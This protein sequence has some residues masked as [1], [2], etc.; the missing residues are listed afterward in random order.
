VLSGEGRVVGDHLC[1]HP[2]VDHI[3]FTGSV[4]TGKAVLQRAALNIKPT[5]MELGGKSAAILGAD[6]NLDRALTS[7][8]LGIFE[9]AGQICSACSRL[10]VPRERSAEVRRW[11]ARH[12]AS[13]TVGP[14]ETDPSMGPLISRDQQIRVDGLIERALA[15]GAELVARGRLSEPSAGFFV[16][17][18]V[19]GGVDPDGE[20]AQREVFGP[21]LSI[22]EYHSMEQ[23]VAIANGTRFGLVAGVF[24]NDLAF[25]HAVASQMRVGQVFINEWFA[26]GIE[27][28]FG[29]VGESG[30]GREKGLDGVMN[31]VRSRNT[32]IRYR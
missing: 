25:A 17:P 11:F 30:F 32:A 24:T 12:V 13:M 18:T 9:N 27:T 10:L 20:I 29:G 3:V 19:L 14:G 22:I 16:P 31:Y 7:V 21:V 23:A 2:G 8:A 4:A 26:G 1:A 28:P 15:G 5:V 6:V